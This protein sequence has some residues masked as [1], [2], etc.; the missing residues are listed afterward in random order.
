MMMQYATSCGKL[1]MYQQS[2]AIDAT[3]WLWWLSMHKLNCAKLITSQHMI[4]K[5]AQVRS[6]T[7]KMHFKYIS[8]NHHVKIFYNCFLMCEVGLGGGSYIRRTHCNT[9]CNA[10]LSCAK[11]SSTIQSNANL[12]RAK[13][14]NQNSLINAGSTLL[15]PV[16]LLSWLY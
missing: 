15:Y 7:H 3:K 6:H 10:K 1:S 13:L 4:L 11:P 5:H 8:K 14:C 16:S 2:P 12:F 9:N